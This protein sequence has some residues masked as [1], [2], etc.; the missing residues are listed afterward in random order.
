[1]GSFAHRVWVDRPGDGTVAWVRFDS[2]HKANVFTTEMLHE[3]VTEIELISK[4]DE[5]PRAL[6]LAGRDDMFSGGADLA[7]IRDMSEAEYVEYI[8]TEYALF[9]LVET[10]PCATVAMLAGA[11]IGNGA[12]L[13]LACDFRIAGEKLKFGLPELA[14]GFI[15]PTQRLTRYLGIGR[16]KELLFESTVLGAERALEL[17]LVS[18]VV[19]DTELH[20]RTAS[21]ASRY[22]AIAPIALELTK[23]RLDD[24][25]GYS[26]ER[27]RQERAEALRTFQSQDFREGSEAV[28]ARR[29]PEFTGR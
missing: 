24:E 13:A 2:D 7:T 1:M 21:A 4:A 11:C 6:V 9:R 14:V 29:T 18:M 22:A 16:A 28:L 5:L 27:D 23:A 3:L 8:D 15:G 25:F 10:L 17:G 26:P 12:E 20:E 19:A